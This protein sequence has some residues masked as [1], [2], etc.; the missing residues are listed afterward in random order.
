MTCH[1][2]KHQ[3]DSELAR[4]IMDRIKWDKRIS[5]ADIEI[6]VHGGEVIVSGEVDSAYRK[7]AAIEAISET[8][9]VWNIEDRIE[10]PSDFYR[11]DNEIVKILKQQILEML[12][13][14]GEH[15]EIECEY[16]IVKLQ[17]EVFRP[18]LK[19][20]AVAFAWELS[21]VKDVNNFIELKSPPQRMPLS[22]DFELISRFPHTGTNVPLDD[23][24]KEVQ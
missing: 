1:L 18:R 17:G 8:E 6:E 20:M 13:L 14:D 2:Q 16:G 10:V 5:L 11:S 15:I 22:V 12:M 3:S 19:A 4:K 9:G 24:L 23:L 21:G 7:H